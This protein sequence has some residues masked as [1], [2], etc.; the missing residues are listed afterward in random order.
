MLS[1]DKNKLSVSKDTIVATISFLVTF[2]LTYGAIWYF[3]FAP[4][5]KRGN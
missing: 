4:M 2:G 5:I 3:I 1:K